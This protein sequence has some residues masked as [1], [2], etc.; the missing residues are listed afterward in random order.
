[1]NYELAKELKNAGFPGMDKI[2]GGGNFVFESIEKDPEGMWIKTGNA[3]PAPT[4]SEL[5][6]FVEGSGKL[7]EITQDYV[8]KA[9]YKL[10]EGKR[11]T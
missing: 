2:F 11:T 7:E 6:D 10:R 5:I 4:L 3:L 8:A 9:L 1:M